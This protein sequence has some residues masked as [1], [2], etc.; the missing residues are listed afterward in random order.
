[1]NRPAEYKICITVTPRMTDD[2]VLPPDVRQSDLFNEDL[3]PVGPERRAWTRWNYAS[4]WIGMAVCVPTYMLAA[5]LIR[6]GMNWWQ[7]LLTVVLGNVIVL[8]PMA[9]NGIPGAKYG[10][11]FPVLIRASFGTR[12]A[13]WAGLMRA[14]VGCGWFGIQSWIGGSAIYQLLLVVWP[15]L[16]HS[17]PLGGWLGL[18]LAQ[19]ACFLGFWAINLWLV[20]HGIEAIRRLESWSAPFLLAMGL[21]LLAWAVTAGGSVEAVLHAS[22]TMRGASAKSVWQVFWP[23]LTAMVGFW[24]TLSLNI[25]DFTRYAKSQRA[26][27]EGQI[28]GLPTTMTLFSF[29]GIFVTSATVLVFG[30]AIWDPVALLGRFHSPLLIALSL[31]ALTVATLT[32]NIAANVVA[33]ANDIANLAPRRIGF[34]TG[35]YITGVV[36]ILMCPWKLIADP[37]GYIFLW[38]IAYSSLLGAVA[39]V[40]I[41]DYFVV[42]RGR[43]AVA[44][45]FKADGIYPRW[46]PRAWLALG[47]SLLPVLPG[48]GIQTGLLD[49]AAIGP[50]WNTLYS[51][52]WFVTLALAFGLHWVFSAWARRRAGG[53]LR[54]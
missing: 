52:A 12:G 20:H 39:G 3:A 35:G 7:A 34:R 43:L 24:A 11:P 22:E 49:A 28:L 18:N 15:G 38:L 36:G 26:Q 27:I 40:M 42:R 32:T 29:I 5:G 53:G 19:S 2:S 33:S 4:L 51:Y 48:F 54:P 9:L 8:V 13:V 1:L 14:A 23:G 21:G 41:C 25:P 37:H 45:L 31:V 17:A 46:N 30:E 16:A 6:E 50:G 10:I 44:D 47:L